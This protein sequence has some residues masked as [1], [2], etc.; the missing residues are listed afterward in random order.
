[1]SHVVL[2]GDSI[3]DN[4]VYVPD[5]P[6]VIEQVRRGLPLG[7]KAT[8]VAVDGHMIEDITTQLGRVP[9]T[10]THLVLSV[11]G[12]NALSASSLLREPAATVG[13]AL[14]TIAE[15]IGEF[16]TAYID[17]LRLVLKL[18]K[19]TCVCTIYDA[20]PVI[21]GAERAA[22]AGFNDIISRTAV[23]AGVPVIDLR[24][25]CNCADDYSPLSPI[26][27]SVTGGA[28]IADTIC[29]MLADHDFTTSRTAVWV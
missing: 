20:V 18:G 22:L 6:P 25:V 10:A 4:A 28:K 15:A 16:R 11:G 19:P 9:S 14:M 26:E 21:G 27:P 5:R 29:R 24:V 8:L 12:N 2:L 17:M 3:F 23:T 13:D 7:W 1:M